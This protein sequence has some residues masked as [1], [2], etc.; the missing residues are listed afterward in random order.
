Q[1][2]NTAIWS[3]WQWCILVEDQLAEVYRVQTVSI[4]FRVNQFQDAVFV[5][6]LRQRQLDDVAGD[7]VIGVEPS[8]DCFK[9]FLGGVF[10]QIFTNRRDSKFFAI[11][12]LHLLIRVRTWIFTYQNGGQP[13]LLIQCGI[14]LFE[15]F[16]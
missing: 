4:F 9:F 6:M 13:W 15:V 14:S 3:T 16:K 2:R 10:W 1:Q 11:A 12:V 5:E 8:N 7:I